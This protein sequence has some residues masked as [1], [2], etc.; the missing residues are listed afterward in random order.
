MSQ[1]KPTTPPGRYVV[2]FDGSCRFCTAGVK[3]L[4]ALARP[5][6]LQTV[7]FQEPGVLEGFPGLTYEDCM[8]A[9]Q[10]VTPGGHIYSG[11]E[12]AVQ[13]VA[14]RRVI[15]WLA[16][17]YYLP[18]LRQLCDWAYAR[19]AANRYRIMGKAIAK[20]DCEGGTCS[21]HADQQAK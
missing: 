7:N 5:G 21:L 18:G 11:F 1:P 14:T 10:L 16:Y 9:M 2:L 12:A 20:G 13:A 19:L 6:T 8:K 17:L 3:K 15:G 4:L